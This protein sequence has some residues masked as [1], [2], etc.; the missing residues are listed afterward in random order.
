[1]VELMKASAG[2]G[3]TYTL[4]K[5]YIGLLLESRERDAYRHILAV[6]FTNKATDEMKSRILKE[7]F[8]MATNPRGSDYLKDFVPSVLPSEEELQRKSARVMS[9]ILHD[10]SAFAVSTID[11]FFQQTLK[12]FAHEI[13]QFAS[14]QVELDRDAVVEESVDRLLDSLTEEKKELRDWLTDNLLDQIERGGKY[15][16]DASLM[17]IAKRLGSRQRKD[18]VKEAG[19]KADVRDKAELRKVRTASRKIITDGYDKLV[20]ASK[21]VLSELGKYGLEVKVDK[22]TFFGHFAVFAR[23]QKGDPAE[24]PGTSFLNKL[25]D[26]S[27][28]FTG[29]QKKRFKADIDVIASNVSPYV[30]IV[31]D[32]FKAENLMDYNTACILDSQLYGL[33]LAGEL[34]QMFREIMKEKNIMCLD[35]S[36]EILRDII[37][38][39]DAPFI[40]EK[41]GVRFDHFLLDEFQDTSRV[42]Y[43]NFLPLLKE[44]HSKGG[45]NLIVGDVK[46]SIYRWRGSDWNLLNNEIRGHFD[47]VEDNTLQTNWRS[48]ADVIRFNN[49]LFWTLARV[50]DR[51]SIS[52]DA[53]EAVKNSLT[54]PESEIDR[55]PVAEIYAD[56]MQKVAPKHKEGGSV[57]VTFVPAPER[58]KGDNGLQKDRILAT[59]E[60]LTS[61]GARLGDIAILVR[62]NAEGE[63]I[64]AFLLENNIAVITDESLKVKKSATVRRLM[65]LMSYVDN[66]AD[67]VNGYLAEQLKIAAPASYRSLI[68]LAE[69]FLRALKC[70]TGDGWR[71]EVPHIQ[72]FMDAIQD[73][74]STR[75][76][77]LHNFLKYWEDK[78]PSIS[79][80]SSGDAVR[81]MT[82][83]KSKGLAFP[84]VILPYAEKIGFYKSGKMWCAPQLEGTRLEG[85]AEGTYDV[86][87]SEASCL[88]H[89]NRHY[90]RESFL[91]LVDNMNI[92]YVALTRA[93]KGMHIIANVPGKS[94]REN[95]ESGI[96]DFKNFAEL[97]YWFVS[98]SGILEG[99]ELTI[100]KNEEEE[101]KDIL[102]FL[103]GTGYDFNEMKRESDEM[104]AFVQREGD[105]F[106]S[107]PLNPVVP[108][109]EQED[110]EMV[111][112]RELSRLKFSADSI[113]FFSED[114]AGIEASPRL[115]GI[116]LHDILSRLTDVSELEDAVDAAVSSGDVDLSQREELVALLNERILSKPEWFAAEGMKVMNETSLID[117]DGRM[118]RPDRVMIA[119]DGSVCIVD[120]KFGEHHRTYERQLRGYADIWRRMGYTDVTAVLW[121]VNEDKVIDVI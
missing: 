2:S 55:G 81:V 87:L 88:T 29:D 11:K 24:M 110:G 50:V 109:T 85:V 6:T 104:D 41:T 18:A 103:Y 118:Y 28:W 23:M 120:Y 61:K 3:K 64:A 10:Y 102:D 97:I 47:K 35:D 37:N 14:Y 93:E 100:E 56:V 51:Q 22:R 43:D 73:Y 58:G 65:S 69:Y 21:A 94:R 114:K 79:S 121:Y 17:D 92:L 60:D 59:I 108:V 27:K 53:V 45:R 62:G 86:M 44:S 91:Q 8:I 95:I 36:N 70:Q 83:H 25:A 38:G 115:K 101:G 13:G 119:A 89:F 71:N 63:K 74:V 77:S 40:Y 99:I 112:V 106:P 82:V 15:R 7:L 98:S 33:G 20:E 32:F 96:Y 34:E 19:L 78:D 48:L 54:D 9:D 75:D 105:E 26:A 30:S 90:T 31:E 49:V 16:V 116:L 68:D 12:A 1:M 39:S 80:P 46:Q 111:D 5:K 107:V 117:S 72:S 113:D 52:E 42:Q 4:A 84:Y 76:N 66:P 67:M 57:R